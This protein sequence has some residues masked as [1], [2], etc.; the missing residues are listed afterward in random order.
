MD[1]TVAV[2]SV[3]G[4]RHRPDWKR[5]RAAARVLREDPNRTDMAFEIAQA[6]EPDWQERGFERL[7]ARPE[8]RRLFERRPDLLAA[9]KD[10][11]VLQAMPEGS[12]G[13]AFLDHIDR[14]DLSP[15]ALIELGRQGRSGA[16]EEGPAWFAERYYLL[17][18]LRHV[19][20]GYGA[21]PLG[22]TL[23]LWFSHAQDGGLSNRLLMMSS[24]QARLQTERVGLGFV[25]ACLRAW[26]RGRKASWLDVMPFEDLLPLPVDE[27]RRLAG[28]KP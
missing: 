14:Y 28:I 20:A 27:V 22:E 10:R 11:A 18:D 25:F 1:V 3:A 21:D 16:P 26:L 8:G 7:I 23:V 12:F 19:L 13:Q 6:L 4:G 15:T 9:L 17:H 2:P 5:A 24:L